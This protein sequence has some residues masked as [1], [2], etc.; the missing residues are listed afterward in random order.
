MKK[1]V[2]AIGPKPASNSLAEGLGDT[3]SYVLLFF[4]GAGIGYVGFLVE[5]A[6]RAKSPALT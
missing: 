6:R 3:F 2:P 1:A 4:L 5:K